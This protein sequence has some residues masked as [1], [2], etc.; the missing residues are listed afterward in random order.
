MV[1]TA[2]KQHSQASRPVVLHLEP[3]PPFRLDLTVWA[4]R[5]QPQ[6]AVDLWD[7]TT[8]TRV[9]ATDG[10]PVIARVMQEGGPGHPHLRVGLSC[11]QPVSKAAA[12]SISS[13]LGTMLGIDEDLSLFY[14]NADEDEQL[15]Q[16]AAEFTGLRPPRFPSLFEALINAFA[17]QQISL[18]VCITLLNRL[19]LTYGREAADGAV[20]LHAFPGPEQLASA[21]PADLRELG[22][23]RNKGSAIVGLS[24]AMLDGSLDPDEIASLNDEEAIERLQEIPG[25]GRW[26]AEYVLL[27]GLRRLNIFPGD[28]AGA[29]N[30]IQRFL[31]LASKPD[32]AG[33]RRIMQRW[34]PYQGFVYF[35][36]L[37]RKLKA[38][39]AL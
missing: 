31:S 32:S 21:D 1:Q 38:G 15:K 27:R 17:C 10:Q 24:K 25:V 6:N 18:N 35:H 11:A 3:R 29:Q 36:F 14:R 20:R 33:V 13:Q 7:G 8:Y 9:F 19:V 37:L 2:K 5:R 26:S 39:G 28:D 23:S 22:F 30:S 12:A 34:A 16:L 4:L